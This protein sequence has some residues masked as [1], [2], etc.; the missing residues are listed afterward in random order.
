MFLVQ[1][2]NDPTAWSVGRHVPEV[3][4][5]VKYREELEEARHYE[6]LIKTRNDWHS[7]FAHRRISE[8]MASRQD[9]V[10][11]VN[12]RRA[13]TAPEAD[14][15]KDFAF[16]PFALDHCRRS[17]AQLF[18]DLWVLFESGCKRGGFF[19]EFGAM[20]GVEAS[21]TFLLETHYEW[22]GIVAEP[23]PSFHQ[24]L[25]ANR[26][27]HVSTQCVAPVSNTTVPFIQ[28][29][30]PL[31]STI[32]HYVSSDMHAELRKDGNRITVETISLLDLLREGG[33]PHVIDYLSIDT[34]GNEL[35]I[36]QSFDFSLYEIRLISVEHNYTPRRQAIHALLT[37]HGYQRR[38][39]ELSKWDDWYVKRP[40][41]S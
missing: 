8:A 28:T 15:T 1:G 9:R 22:S 21:N 13:S 10:D 26:K 27:C 37:R 18:Q 29:T 14:I 7:Y 25:R 2:P 39:T 32:E 6:A 11:W 20:D 40:A 30:D 36:L 35:E 16:L 12:L 3:G 5:P 38:F 33:A 4:M 31:Y 24:A 41:A 34:E 19:V 23:N 17:E